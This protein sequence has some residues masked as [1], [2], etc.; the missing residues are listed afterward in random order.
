[1]ALSSPAAGPTAPQPADVLDTEALAARVRALEAENA[2]LSRTASARPTGSR[3]R[4]AASALCI[5][6]AAILVPVSIAGAWARVQLVDEDAFVQTLAP[7]VDDANVQGLIIDESMDAIRAQVDFA[8]VTGSVIDGVKDLGV[9]PR[10]SAALDLLQQPAADALENLVASTVTTVVESDAFSDIWATTVRGAHRALTVAST[11]D[12]G[13]I[14]VQTR[15][16]VGIALGPIVEQVK[17]RLTA[18]GL[19]VASLI[20]AIDRTIIIGSGETLGLIRT[21]YAIAATLGWWLPVI[22]LALFAL[23]IALARRR[24][25]AVLGTGVALALGGASLATALSIGA[26]AVA[27]AAGQLELSPSALDVVYARLV[28]DMMQTGWVIALL[29]VVVA[30]AGWLTGRSRPAVRTRATLDS[31]GASA[32]RS[33]AARGLDTGGFGVWLA[34][35]RVLVRVGVAVL[36]VL[37]LFALRPLGA[38]DVFLVL[39]V[40]LVVAWVLELLQRRP[41]ERGAADPVGDDEITTA[42]DAAQ[43][44]DAS[45]PV[46]TAV[47]ASETSVEATR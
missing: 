31:L 5:V 28:G 30:I 2:T 14:V 11:S 27:M 33:L 34:R 25:T 1:M 10:A 8:A 17:E 20:P 29:G 3:W 44:T 4:A 16:G 22:T 18:N 42:D 38:G 41:E 26:T 45:T 37:W 43:A 13:G 23:G 32:R 21:S 7:L 40:A 6:V 39:I 24:A 47:E 46:E 12:G 19:G 36:A 35:N 9:G 15:D